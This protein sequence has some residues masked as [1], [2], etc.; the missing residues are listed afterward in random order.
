MVRSVNARE[1]TARPRAGPIFAPH[2]LV[3]PIEARL[4]P[5]LPLLASAWISGPGFGLG[6]LRLRLC[7]P[8]LASLAATS[9]MRVG[10]VTSGAM[11]PGNV[12]PTSFLDWVIWNPLFHAVD[13]ARG[14]AFVNYAP[15]HSLGWLVHVF[16]SE[17]LLVGAVACHG[18]IVNKQWT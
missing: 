13:Q 17:A 18:R 9:W 7:R 5:A 14:L 11:F 12:L 4:L 3:E 1:D 2:A 10:M 6:L 8:G 15:R 16:A